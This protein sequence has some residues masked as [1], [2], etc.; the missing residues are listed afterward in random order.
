MYFAPVR[1]GYADANEFMGVG[2]FAVSALVALFVNGNP[3]VGYGG[4]GAI[5]LLFTTRAVSFLF[6]T[7]AKGHV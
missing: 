4:D 2:G 7:L 6:V 3:F 5:F 1:R